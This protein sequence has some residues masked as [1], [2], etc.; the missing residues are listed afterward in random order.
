MIITLTGFMGCGKTS[1]GRELSGVLGMRWVDLDHF[2]EERE[3]ATIREIFRE[4]GETEFRRIES[5]AL[6]IILSEKSDTIL[7]LGG[8]TILN[9]SNAELVKSKTVC[10]YL[11]ARAK[12]LAE[13]LECATERPLLDHPDEISL[14]EHISELLNKREEF[15]NAVAEYTINVDGLTYSQTATEISRLISR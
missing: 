14:E 7:S 15:Y 6:N 9:P 3:G 10:F 2:I 1:V 12:S 11:K 5:E 8:G 13:W 4:N